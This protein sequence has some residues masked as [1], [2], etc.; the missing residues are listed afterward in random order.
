[1]RADDA[2][3]CRAAHIARAH[4]AQRP[5]PNKKSL[6]NGGPFFMIPMNNRPY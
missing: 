4:R 1:M 2:T 3:R 5:K 6:L